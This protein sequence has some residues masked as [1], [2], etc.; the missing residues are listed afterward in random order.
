M[1][2]RN[3]QHYD[4]YSD[5][6]VFYFNSSYFW[7]GFS[8]CHIPVHIKAGHL[9]NDNTSGGFLLSYNDMIKYYGRVNKN[10]ILV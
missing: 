2:N 10:N 7:W 9:A 5:F 1:A 6:I 4:S 3:L 8:N